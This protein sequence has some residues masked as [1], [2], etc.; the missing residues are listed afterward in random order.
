MTNRLMVCLVLGV[1]ALPVALPSQQRTGYGELPNE[2]EG[3]A[4]QIGCGPV[5]GFYDRDGMVDPAYLYGWLPGTRDATAVFWCYRKDE[6]SPYL[7]VFV[8]GLGRGGE[9]RVTSTIP[10][11]AFPGGLSLFNSPEVRFYGTENERN[12][13]PRHL[14][15]DVFVY[16]DNP[17]EHGPK[18]KSTEYAPLQES[19]AGLTTIIYRHEGRWLLSGLE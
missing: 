9:G 1:M 16:L 8:E 18:G 11:D 17:E 19:Y 6:E 15:L 13:D 12:Y 2:L 14:P 3:L 7:L 10:W 4:E 5:P